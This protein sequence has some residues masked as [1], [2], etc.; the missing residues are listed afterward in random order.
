M[1]KRKEG[2]KYLLSKEFFNC[3]G[4]GGSLKFLTNNDYANI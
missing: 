1:Q 2:K 4:G 3:R